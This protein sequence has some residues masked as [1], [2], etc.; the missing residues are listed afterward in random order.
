VDA[1]RSGCTSQPRRLRRPPL[2]YGDDV[3]A[4][5]LTIR[6]CFDVVKRG[7]GDWKTP[8]SG[9]VGIA[10]P[11]RCR[12]TAVEIY[13][14]RAPAVADHRTAAVQALTEWAQSAQAAMVVAE[15]AVEARRSC[16]SSSG[17][18]PRRRTAAILAGLEVG[19]QPMA[20]LRSFDIIQRNRRPQRH[21]P[22]GRGAWHTGMRSS[23][24][25]STA[26]RCKMRGRRAGSTNWQTVRL[27]HGPRPVPQPGNR[28]TRGGS[29]RKRCSSPAPPRSSPA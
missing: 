23:S 6:R 13:Q 26:T 20:A 18:S 15:Q 9:H 21:H 8:G 16:P 22:A 10:Y 3:F 4:E 1:S 7:R 27:D 2:A 29:S 25:E 11:R 12:V 24:L 19:F 14:D 28:R 5:F 17:A